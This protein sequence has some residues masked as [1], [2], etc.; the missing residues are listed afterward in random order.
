MNLR[1]YIA[2]IRSNLRLMGRDRSVL[3]FSYLFPLSF[4]FL[5]AQS[6]HA[7]ESTGAMTQ[8]I[9]M[10]LIIGVLGNG[11]FG[12]GMRAV[13]DRE[14][15][16]LR[17]FKVAPVGPLPIIVAGI[18]SGLV[19]FFPSVFLFFF[20]GTIIY[21][22][23]LP[24]N[25]L[26]ILV[27]LSI[28]VI[29]FRALGMIIAGVVNSMQEMSI[30]TQLLYLPMLFL[31]GATF[32]LSMMPVWLQ[33]IAQFLP[34]TYLFQGLQSLMLGGESFFSNIIPVVALIITLACCFA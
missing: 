15:N 2:Q 24:H 31:S 1:P 20:F 18:V 22:A 25:L 34:A 10:V 28:G 21:R 16:V 30:I 32:P 29:A 33:S 13:Q 26:S 8:V 19:A 12:A 23:P 9:T 27:F 6:F 14:T 7:T 4:F 3:F 17:R 5:F 11:F